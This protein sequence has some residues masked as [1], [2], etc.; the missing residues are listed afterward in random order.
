MPWVKLEEQGIKSVFQ[1]DKQAVL[2][3]DYMDTKQNITSDYLDSLYKL[4]EQKYK[5]KK[6]DAVIVTDDAAY[7]FALAHQQTLFP[8]TPIIFC[9]VNYFDEAD[10]QDK[11]W[12]T[13]IIEDV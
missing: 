6:F 9:G 11:A 7:D 4:Y 10:I 3:F 5:G 1:Q 2:Y 12:V 13:G 8:S